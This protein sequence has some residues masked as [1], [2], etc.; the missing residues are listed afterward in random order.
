MPIDAERFEAL[1]DDD[2]ATSPGTNAHELLSFLE[3]NPD[4]A[5][6]QSELAAATSVTKGSLGPTLVRLRDAGH[7]EHRGNYWRISDHARSVTAATNHASDVAASYEDEP[8]AYDEW[9]AHAVDPR[10]TRE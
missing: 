6:T 10:E 9:Q 7:V 3:S 4:Q 8:P 2:G 5:F 1:D